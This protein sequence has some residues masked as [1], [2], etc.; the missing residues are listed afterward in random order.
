M[1]WK[2]RGR[3]ELWDGGVTETGRG[4]KNWR[5]QDRA[6]RAAEEDAHTWNSGRTPLT[7]FFLCFFACA[8]NNYI[9]QLWYKHLYSWCKIKNNKVFV[10]GHFLPTD[11]IL[12]TELG[13]FHLKFQK[14]N[15]PVSFMLCNLR[16]M[17]PLFSFCTLECSWTSCVMLSIMN[18]IIYSIVSAPQQML[19]GNLATSAAHSTLKCNM[20]GPSGLTPGEWQG[21]VTD[22]Q[23]KFSLIPTNRLM[24]V[25]L[26]THLCVCSFS[27]ESVL[28]CFP[29]STAPNFSVKIFF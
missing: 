9:L 18:G 4:R 15:L 21:F 5:L 6:Q 16:W 12:F 1:Q 8:F 28:L 24:T 27:I 17:G 13:M 14:R 20:R 7:L 10:W 11:F 29:R 25:Y 19:S 26:L 23:P 3:E 22:T 2:E